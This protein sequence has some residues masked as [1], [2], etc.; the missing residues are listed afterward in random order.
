MQAGAAAVGFF[1]LPLVFG[2]SR[3]ELQTELD[4][5]IKKRFGQGPIIDI[6]KNPS[7]DDGYDDID[8]EL[9]DFDRALRD[10]RRR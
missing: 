5:A 7:V 2:K 9:D 8:R 6:E 4:E 3:S 1:L 10:R